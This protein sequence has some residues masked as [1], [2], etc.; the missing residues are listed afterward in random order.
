MFNQFYLYLQSKRKINF[1][2]EGFKKVEIT[3]FC[4]S[5]F[6]ALSNYVPI[7]V[8]FLSRYAGIPTTHISATEAA[9]YF[10]GLAF[11]HYYVIT[12][13]STFSRHCRAADTR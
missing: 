7:E 6:E 4:D 1:L 10:T 5:T 2:L 13:L 11:D 3:P 12:Q 8:L 9:V